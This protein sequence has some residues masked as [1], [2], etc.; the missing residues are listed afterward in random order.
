[1][2][3]LSYASIAKLYIDEATDIITAHIIEAAHSSI[4]QTSGRN[5]N[6]RR[7]WWKDTCK[8]ARKQQNRAG[9]VLRRY[10]TT[11]NL[12]AFKRSKTNGCRIKLE[13]KT[14]S[15][16]TFLASINSYTDT[17]E[18]W[19]RISALQERN[20]NTLPLVSTAGD[21]LED[22][23]NALGQRF[24]S[25]SSSSH[26]TAQFLK[27][28]KLMKQKP[29]RKKKNRMGYNCPF[30]KHEFAVVLSTCRKT[31]PGTDKITFE[32]LKHVHQ[33]TQEAIL[34][35]FNKILKRIYCSS[36]TKRR[37]GYL[38]SC[39]L[40]ADCINKLFMQAFGEDDKQTPCLFFR[41]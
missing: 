28:K 12:L 18:V 1:M 37:Q 17:Q 7:P 35:L 15:W 38:F 10:P 22:Q 14:D 3:Q 31:A 26:H 6:K 32:M 23:A 24:E 13:A 16:K 29:L 2:S 30:T 39:Q 41:A 20:T 27:H 21:T 19:K 5:N 8:I 9:A 36:N 40:Q 11:E 25:V 4:P 33:D 34:F